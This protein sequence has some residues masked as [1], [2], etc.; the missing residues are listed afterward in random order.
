MFQSGEKLGKFIL[1]EKLGS[2]AFGVVWLAESRTA[3]TATQVAL[4]IPLDSDIDI[5]EVIKEAHLWV[6]AS[7]HP[8]VLPIIEADIYN[9]HLVIAT[10]FARDGSL[11][12]LLNRCGGKAPSVEKAVEITSGILAGL[13]HLHVKGIVHRDL[14]PNNILFQGEIP[15]LADFGISR[16]L[17]STTQSRST[18]GTPAYM[19]PEAF[20]GVRNYQTDI[21]SVGII[22]YQLLAGHLPFPD[23][24]IASLVKAI[25]FE[26]PIKSETFFPV[27]LGS[28]LRQALAKDPSERFK[29]AAEMR[30][31]LQS[32]PIRFELMMQPGDRRPVPRSEATSYPRHSRFQYTVRHDSEELTPNE[33]RQIQTV[34]TT[35]CDAHY[36]ECSV[37]KNDGGA[38]VIVRH[39]SSDPDE[40]GRDLFFVLADEVFRE[41][42]KSVSYLMV[43]DMIQQSISIV[44]RAQR[45]P[46]RQHYYFAHAYLAER[47]FIHPP[48]LIVNSLRSEKGVRTL[49]TRWML[50]SKAKGPDDELIPPDGLESIPFEIGDEY[51]GVVVKLP[52]PAGMAEAYFT[53]YLLSRTDGG[54]WDDEQGSFTCRYFTLELSMKESGT[55]FTIL[56]EWDG[57]SHIHHGTGPVPD[58][59]AFIQAIERMVN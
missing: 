13:D 51:I 8:N 28:V 5:D 44:R 32:M 12:D 22:L 59:G 15:R 41:M 1:L 55:T 53:A 57:E 17:G 6:R 23:R 27:I 48:Q 38:L 43:E 14:K 54:D 21:W 4:K 9:G 11:Q 49:Y 25:L 35:W 3:I 29:T 56:G 46:R 58:A 2:G 37:K 7:G 10:E 33:I 26:E 45:E 19:A 34:A 16:V 30:E 24:D 52:T 39:S 18:A 20:D 42:N 31:R 40:V 50:S 36:A 47:A